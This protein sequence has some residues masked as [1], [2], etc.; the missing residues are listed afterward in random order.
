M[1]NSFKYKVLE[2]RF[3]SRSA[4]L[5]S[6]PCFLRSSGSG[7]MLQ[8]KH[9]SNPGPSLETLPSV[10]PRQLSY[11]T[12]ICVHID[13][14]ERCELPSKKSRELHRK[15]SLGFQRR[16]KARL[17]TRQRDR[18]TRIQI[19][20]WQGFDMCGWPALIST[21]PGTAV[22]QAM[23]QSPE[24]RADSSAPYLREVGPS[25]HA[26]VLISRLIK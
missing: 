13:N 24:V 2:A 26:V 12:I 1:G 16:V 18:Q 15:I 23:F 5:L 8:R 19:S 3:D 21:V 10:P 25:P 4:W 17:K 22:H 9:S 11:L 7:L 20:V 6:L 14:C